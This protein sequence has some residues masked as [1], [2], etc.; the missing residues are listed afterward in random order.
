MKNTTIYDVLLEPV[1]TEKTT[2]ESKEFNKYSFKVMPSANK[3]AIKSAVEKVFNV[4]VENVH[5][6]NF[7]GK[8]RRVR[9]QPGFTSSWKKATV[10][11]KKGDK[12]DLT[13]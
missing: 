9:Y 1:I 7:A 11:L 8:K 12:I 6:S 4:H 2:R 10:T 5:T 13:S 3:K